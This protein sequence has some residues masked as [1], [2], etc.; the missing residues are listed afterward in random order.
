MIEGLRYYTRFIE[1]DRDYCRYYNTPL[2]FMNGAWVTEIH[3]T[4]I[5]PH[6]SNLPVGE[7]FY[8]YFQGKFNE[9]IQRFPDRDIMEFRRFKN[10][11]PDELTVYKYNPN[12]Q[13]IYTAQLAHDSSLYEVEFDQPSGRKVYE[14]RYAPGGKSVHETRFF[15]NA[16]GTLIKVKKQTYDPCLVEEL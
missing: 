12:K 15:Y 4:N 7:Y 9:Y 2:Q 8:S 6:F 3:I 10:D 16:K 1:N 11:C 14:R 13:L 5:P